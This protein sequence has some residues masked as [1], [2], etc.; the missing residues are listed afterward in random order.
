MKNES[1]YK[2]GEQILTR[3]AEN[4]RFYAMPAEDVAVEIARKLHGLWDWRGTMKE[5]YAPSRLEG[6]ANVWLRNHMKPAADGQHARV[7]EVPLGNGESKYLPYW[8]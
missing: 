4:T 5:I 3:A 1:Q 7:K 6:L 8:K 2:K